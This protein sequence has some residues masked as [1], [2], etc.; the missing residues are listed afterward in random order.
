MQN[1]TIGF[2]GLLAVALFVTAATLGGFQFENYDVLSQ[3]ISETAAIDAPYGKLLRW[4]G[5]VPSGIL[6]TIFF[7]NANRCFV[8]STP[9]KVG[10]IGL[11]IFYGLGTL[12]V[13][14]FPCDAGCNKEFV[15]PSVSQLIHV[16]TGMLTYLFVPPSLL[17]IG[18]GLRRSSKSLGRL[19][20]LSALISFSLFVVII[21]NPETG[22]MGL[23]Q[24]IIEGSFVIWTA[25]CASTILTSDND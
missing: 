25:F 20:I 1:K 7:L 19:A 14:I 4:A 23:W 11:A 21:G 24:R 5:Y 8:R 16:A 18:I 2:I 9:V 17:L 13:G 12:V 10:F 22:L 6:L 15:D 3:L